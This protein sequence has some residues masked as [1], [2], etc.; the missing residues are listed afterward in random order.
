MATEPNLVLKEGDKAPAFEATTQDGK[1]LSLA[2]FKGRS[3]ILYFYPR[4][5]TPG[6]T[7]EACG[8]RDAFAEFERRGAVL[9][10]LERF[11]L[12]VV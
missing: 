6:C 11:L 4:D 3:V 5:Y 10:S 9:L 1:T 12:P 2:D 8:F 7:K